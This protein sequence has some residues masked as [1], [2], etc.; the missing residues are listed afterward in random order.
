VLE[1]KLN[2]IR[3]PDSVSSVFLKI[4]NKETNSHLY[5]VYKISKGNGKFRTICAPKQELKDAQK[6]ILKNI[7]YRFPKLFQQ[8][9][10]SYGFRVNRNII[11]AAQ[12]HK[13][14][15]YV[16]SF[17]ISNFFDNCCMS[18]IFYSLQSSNETKSI[19]ISSDIL[20]NN[21][22]KNHQ[23]LYSFMATMC[24]YSG[25]R[26][27]SAIRI[28]PFPQGA[29]TSPALANCCLFNFDSQCDHYFNRPKVEQ[30]KYISKALAY[31]S[32]FDDFVGSLDFINNIN[33][34][35]YADDIVISFNSSTKLNIPL[36]RSGF[37]RVID[38]LLSSYVSNVGSKTMLNRK[39]SKVMAQHQQQNVLGIV[40]NEDQ[41]VPRKY[42][43]ELRVQLHKY[44]AANSDYKE[45]STL[46]GK[47]NWVKSINEKQYNSLVS[48][49]NRKLNKYHRGESDEMQKPE[50]QG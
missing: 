36:I 24:S 6:W 16:L 1:A 44:A 27:L 46:T 50:M 37:E 12:K 39:K 28:A 26:P 31:N 49:Y 29:P 22:P 43:D 34:T 18:K 42:R 10:S 4:I 47:L 8:H 19:K 14:K 5:K 40:L 7:I 41:S 17:D 33:Y 25:K 45:D 2:Y 3:I 30:I 13:H 32:S 9:D 23:N 48:F 21:I 20:N 11:Q 15:D 38:Y 35:R